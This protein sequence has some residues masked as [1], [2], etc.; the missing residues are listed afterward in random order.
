M[1][2]RLSPRLQ[3]IADYVLPGAT[4]IDVG[5]DHAYI[6]IWL[7]QNGI[8][9]EAYAT[10]IKP[11]P[12]QNAE[13]D[14]VRYGVPGH[15][16]LTLCD[17]LQGCSADMGDT[18]II[19]GMG[20]ET[21]MGIL[22]AAPWA[23]ERRLIL[24]PQTK[25]SELRSWLKAHGLAILDA[26]LVY[27]AGRIYLIWLVGAGTLRE[28]DAIDPILVEKREPLLKPYIEYH[29]KRLR[30][31]VHGMSGSSTASTEL[32]RAYQAELDE[33]LRIYEEVV[34]WQA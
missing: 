34:Q 20:G 17:G 27:D 11:G 25:Q 7:L 29:I 8:S 28:C 26:S 32:L 18:V 6:P 13:R 10:D 5:T 4:V 14:A 24:Q 3:R 2:V 23:W 12:L 30:K 19:A 22:D 9:A 1:S 33:L 16:H 15:L 31:Q 21:I